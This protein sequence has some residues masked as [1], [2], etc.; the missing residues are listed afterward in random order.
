M[1]TYV[2]ENSFIFSI[3]TEPLCMF[4]LLP[5]GTPHLNLTRK[6]IYPIYYIREK[7][8]KYIHV[9][10]SPQPELYGCRDL[11]GLIVDWVLPPAVISK[12]MVWFNRNTQCCKL[13]IFTSIKIQ[14]IISIFYRYPKLNCLN[15][16]RRKRPAEESRKT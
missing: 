10:Y 8:C 15:R 16:D 3:R 12:K 7:A 11:D 13:F 1:F 14:R 9:F 6:K 5:T 2:V 4:I